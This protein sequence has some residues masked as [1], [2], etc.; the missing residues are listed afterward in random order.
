MI[1]HAIFGLLSKMRYVVS[2]MLCCSAAPSVPDGCIF[3]GPIS[4]IGPIKASCRAGV[5]VVRNVDCYTGLY[6]YVY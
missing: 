5:Q 1:A 6:F 2:K 4:P 3:I